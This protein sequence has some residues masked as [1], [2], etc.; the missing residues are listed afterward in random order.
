MDDPLDNAV[1]FQ[2][3]ELLNQHLLRDGRYRA[4]KIGKAKHL[5]AEEMEENNQL[6]AAFQKLE[7]LLDAAG[8]GRRCVF[9]LLTRR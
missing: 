4:L 2:L 3:P 1:A 5:L 8:G 9:V 7:G 6:P